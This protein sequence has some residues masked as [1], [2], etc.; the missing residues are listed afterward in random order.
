MRKLT[1]SASRLIATVRG[2]VPPCV[3]AAILATWFN[4]WTTGRRFQDRS[5]RCRFNQA[6]LGEDSIE[7]YAVCAFVWDLASRSLRLRPTPRSLGRFLGL[8][9]ADHDSAISMALHIFAAYG[10][11]NFFQACCRFVH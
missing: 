6:C 5:C 3:L 1:A 8:Q 9:L 11:F 4:G 2:R 10:T 7:H